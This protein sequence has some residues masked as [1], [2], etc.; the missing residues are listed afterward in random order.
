MLIKTSKI[1]KNKSVQLSQT[2]EEQ[3]R[4]IEVI[5]TQRNILEENKKE[6]IDK[7][8]IQELVIHSFRRTQ[9]S[10]SLSGPMSFLGALL[11][12][13]ENKINN[14]SQNENEESVIQENELNKGMIIDKINRNNNIT[15][16]D[17]EENIANPIS[18][19]Q[20]ENQSFRYFLIK[21]LLI[22]Q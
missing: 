16:Y 10:R 13:L 21:T 17:L 19:Y 6:L 3:A 18:T 12:D 20:M 14:D 11:E 22:W 9:M 4:L 2:I 1:L 5:K 8:N 7:I 15:Y